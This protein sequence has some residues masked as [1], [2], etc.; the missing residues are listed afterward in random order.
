MN[1]GASSEG[2]GSSLRLRGLPYQACD[3]DVEAFFEGFDVCKV[4]IVKKN[5]RATGE[6]FAYFNSDADAAHALR[7]KNKLTM[8]NRYIELFPDGKGGGSAHASS[9][10][11]AYAQD[12]HDAGRVS[13]YASSAAAVPAAPPLSFSPV[14]NGM[15]YAQASKAKSEARTAA[16]A[17]G[18][19][20]VAALAQPEAPVAATSMTY[21][22][23]SSAK[24]PSAADG[25]HGGGSAGTSARSLSGTAR[26][27]VVRMRGLP[28]TSNEGDIYAFFDGLAMRELIFTLNSSGRPTGEAFVEFAEN[29]SLQSV[30]AFHKQM[31]GKRYIEIF[32]AN[33]HEMAE[34]MKDMNKHPR[35][36]TVHAGASI[37]GASAGAQAGVT[38]GTSVGP[39]S[40]AAL[41]GAPALEAVA[42]GPGNARKLVGQSK[43]QIMATAPKGTVLKLRGLPYTTGETDI[44]QFFGG[45]SVVAMSLMTRPEKEGRVGT[46]NGVAYVQFATA[47]EAE[48]AKQVKHKQIMGNRYIECMV[49]ISKN[50]LTVGGPGAG[51]AAS[52]TGLGSGGEIQGHA[53]AG[54]G[55][56][57]DASMD[58]MQGGRAYGQAKATNPAMPAQAP[59]PFG[60]TNSSGGKV[61]PQPPRAWAGAANGGVPGMHGQGAQ[62]LSLQQ[63]LQRMGLSERGESLFAD[64]PLLLSAQMQMQMQ[65]AAGMPVARAQPNGMAP[66]AGSYDP[67]G[68]QAAATPTNG[69]GGFAWNGQ[70]MVSQ[71]MM[72]QAQMAGMHPGAASMAEQQA[73]ANGLGAHGHMGIAGQA[74]PHVQ[75]VAMGARSNGD[76]PSQQGAA[77]AQQGGEHANGGFSMWGMGGLQ[78][79]GQGFNGYALGPSFKPSW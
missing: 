30:L 24:A 63:Q 13:G 1:G 68:A 28:F 14:Q 66:P 79:A 17:V 75:A 76:G 70:A 72:G 41:S 49:H 69:R 57:E 46:C 74:Q 50:P 77:P 25:T 62:P 65:Q 54:D 73:M 71:S 48:S 5:G 10:P 20:A 9:K 33:A 45:Y 37:G 51:I 42:G 56:A 67:S 18:G 78:A 36:Q 29:V 15:T 60:V 22:G 26:T 38:N 35:K 43:A 39:R 59:V 31:M 21:A 11:Q 53:D 12:A 4:V 34:A 6:A 3:K 16:S 61:E 40:G 58:V 32:K 44:V 47:S 7:T 64:N 8:G 27:V 2:G 23:V 19:V 52:A 55:A